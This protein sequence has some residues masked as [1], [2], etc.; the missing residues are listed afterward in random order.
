VVD[1]TAYALR[2]SESRRNDP[3]DEHGDPFCAELGRRLLLAQYQFNNWVLRR[4]EKV[5]FASDRRVAR[6]TSV[7]L[8]VPEEAPVIVY[9]DT[10]DPQGGGYWLVPLSVM[11][12][13]TLVG[14][15]LRDEDGTSLRM[16]GLRF[17]QKLDESL[18]RAAALLSHAVTDGVL[19]HEVETYIR[20]VVSG[21]YQQVSQA[22]E[23]FRRWQSTKADQ[24]TSPQT[25]PDDACRRPDEPSTLQCLFDDTLF[26]TVLERLWHNFTLYVLLPADESRRHR[27]LQIA[28]E[29]QVTWRYQLPD[30]RP[31][32]G[33]SPGDR[34]VLLYQPLRRWVKLGAARDELLGHKTTRLRLLIPSAENCASYHFE[35]TA[36]TG[37]GISS[38]ALLAGRPNAGT[39]RKAVSW[40]RVENPGQ[41]AGLH[42]VEIPNGSLCRAQVDL[43]IPSRG[44]LATLTLS[45]WAIAIVMCS[46]LFHARLF[47][48]DAREWSIDQ[49]T[50]IVLL[51]V[52]VTVGAVTYVAQHHAGDV[53]ARMVSGLRVVGAASLT[54]PAMATMLL[55]YLREQPSDRNRI[56]VVA[57]LGALTGLSILTAA[58]LTRAWHATFTSER[59][60]GAPSP[61]QMTSIDGQAPAQPSLLR[62]LFGTTTTATE[63]NEAAER[64]RAHVAELESWN[65]ATFDEL[66]VGLG[67]DQ[68]SIGVA[69]AE[70]WHEIYGWDDSKQR[71]CVRRLRGGGR[72]NPNPTRC[73][74]D[75]VTHDA[76]SSESHDSTT[77]A[78]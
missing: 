46:V 13:R 54:I 71:E 11:R 21:D 45:T 26:A 18:L 78:R 19:P 8:R 72:P 63:D 68:K 52:T 74:C 28:F 12:R 40:D 70:G 60:V 41:S 33:R 75:Q 2:A 47:G 5:S 6:R 10:H 31:P 20:N 22:K 49:V 64:Q 15:D 3:E 50:N 55:V 36:P 43:R 39:T 35:F 25:A 51:L 38:A 42:A 4:V 62:D 7:E 37:L 65:K 44:W 56:W 59:R 9:P 67:F 61:W 14:L 77:S 17:T 57:I 30:L 76:S 1:P 32:E 73:A 24:E 34:R 16:L 53:V 23:Q 29:E 69:S 48:S 27:L 66:A 58:V